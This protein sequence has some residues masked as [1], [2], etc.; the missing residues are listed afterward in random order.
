MRIKII[1]KEKPTVGSLRI[2]SKFAFLPIRI[3]NE[4]RWL[5]N[6]KIQQKLTMIDCRPNRWCNKKFIN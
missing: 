4:M 5:E 3:E 6:V 2:I 1:S